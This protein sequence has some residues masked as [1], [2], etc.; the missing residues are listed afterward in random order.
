MAPTRSFKPP[1]ITE[2]Q[3]KTLFSSPLES[4]FFQLLIQPRGP[5]DHG[6]RNPPSPADPPEITPRS[7]PRDQPRE[8]MIP[9]F[10]SFSS[11]PNHP[12]FPSL[13]EHGN[14]VFMAQAKLTLRSQAQFKGQEFKKPKLRSQPKFKTRKIRPKE[15]SKSKPSSPKATFF[16]SPKPHP[17][18]L[19]PI[20]RSLYHGAQS[21]P[22][23]AA[24]KTR[25]P[26]IRCPEKS[27]I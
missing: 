8:E 21:I 5:L 2:L 19:S 16:S 26:K 6:E 3:S 22:S 20:S 13:L 27:G 12:H 17:R 14:E 18:L 7:K 15:S 11:S 25:D 10:Y 24:P 23:R 4:H 9:P 1:E